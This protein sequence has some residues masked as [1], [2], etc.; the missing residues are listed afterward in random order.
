M[1]PRWRATA[2]ICHRGD[3]DKAFVGKEGVE[4][5][6]GVMS[7]RVGESWDGSPPQPFKV[8]DATDDDFDNVQHAFRGNSANILTA[9]MAKVRALLFNMN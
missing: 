6:V 1:Y 2:S 8:M 9:D 4:V 5:G 7:H 3:F